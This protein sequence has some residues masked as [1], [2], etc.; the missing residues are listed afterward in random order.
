MKFKTVLI[1]LI[2]FY[3]LTGHSQTSDPALL[4]DTS[5]TVIDK[6]KLKK[7]YNVSKKAIS[8]VIKTI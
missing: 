6:D 7:E 2:A 8:V 1:F 4:M 5:L 3:S